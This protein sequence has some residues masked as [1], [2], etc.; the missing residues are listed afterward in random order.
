MSSEGS[1][2]SSLHPGGSVNQ[3]MKVIMRR[4]ACHLR[5]G[6]LFLPIPENHQ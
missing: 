5:P 6:H 3:H 1:I 4:H 2:S